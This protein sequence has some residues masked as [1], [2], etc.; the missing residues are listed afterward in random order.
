MVEADEYAEAFLEYEPAIALIGNVEPDHLDY[1][2][3]E[4]RLRGAFEA[5]AERVQD[6]G[7]LIVGADSPAAAAIGAARRAAG[8]RVERFGLGGDAEW[9]ATQL[10]PNDEGG[11]DATVLLEGVELGRFSLR[12]P[13]RHNV[14]NAL[15]ALAVAM[16]AGVDFKRAAQAASRFTGTRRRF[17]LLGEAG[18]VTLVD[19]YAH[20]PT[21]IRA[22]LAAARQRYPGRRLVGC[23]QPH[24]YSRSQYLLE[25]FPRLLRGPR[26]AASSVPTYAARETPSQGLDAAAL[27]RE[28]E[29][30]EA[31]YVASFEAAARAIRG[32]AARRRR[33]PHAR[34]RRRR[35]G[36]SRCCARCW[37]ERHDRALAPRGAVRRALARARG[38][39]RLGTLD[40]ARGRR[41]A[42]R[43]HAARHHARGGAWLTPEETQ[44]RLE[45]SEADGTNSL[46][47]EEGAGLLSQ[48]ELLSAL[49]DVAVVFPIVHGRNGEDGTLQ[50]L[51]ELAGTPYVGS[52]VAASAIGMD[53]A[54]MRA[55]FAAHDVP[56]PRYE[57]LRDQALSELISDAPSREA[58]T[59]LEQSVGYPC[60]AKPANGGSSI[61][62]SRVA[63]REELGDALLSAARY[64]RK[65][66]VEEAIDG[67]EIECAV[68]GNA[69]PRPSP[70]GE[71]RP[72]AEFYSYDA[73]YGD[74]GAELIVPV[75]LDER[76]TARVQEI[77]VDA[78]RAVDC[79][80]LA[81]VDFL[82]REPDQVHVLEVNTL[83]G[84][85]PISMYPR[86]WE[87]AGLSYRALI[88]RLVGLAL[89]RHAEA[90]SY[91]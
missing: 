26:R 63:A 1:Y 31:R 45:R 87:E 44:R 73:K 9:R 19:D 54:H 62:I 7:S 50:G 78:Y 30:P 5:F 69:D 41:R 35:P 40:P 36:Y 24:T 28:I 46:G 68:L 74:T 86:L 4:Q 3:S 14:A 76:L 10:R 2:G 48:P 17:E 58:L 89:E 34:R 42:L 22:T 8:A 64:D 60:F 79:A 75:E 49:A 90:G 85:T 33:L 37:R 56:Q 84:F 88:T 20:H 55:V 29:N 15:G 23:F 21:E 43:D 65:V 16:R 53:K 91:A 13:G 71:I 57:V 32:G 83:P 81:R 27:A 59:R 25:R 47:D 52:G 39:G 72:N 82:V 18:G 6:D 67:R 51:L 77:A 11:L 70:L 80:G 12:V 61:G 66:L 38:L